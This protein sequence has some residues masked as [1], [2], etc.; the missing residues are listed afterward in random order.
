MA[1]GQWFDQFDRRD[2]VEDFPG[3]QAVLPGEF[4]E[5]GGDM[6]VADGW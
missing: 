3:W 5:D 4:G 1:I 6:W 2:G